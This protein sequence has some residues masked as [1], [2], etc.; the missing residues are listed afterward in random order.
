MV[1][2]PYAVKLL[3]GGFYESRVVGEDSGLEVAAVAAFHSYTGSG[4]VGGADIGSL[5]IKDQHLKMDARTEHPFKFGRQDR[6]A[7]KILTE[8]RSR[9]FSVNETNL[10]PSF[11]K[12]RKYSKKRNR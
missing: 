6:V 9:L 1:A 10:H 11:Q 3:Y 5:E 2:T 12:I 8:S 4:E 7:V